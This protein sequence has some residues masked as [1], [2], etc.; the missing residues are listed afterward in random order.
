MTYP[1]LM[2]A[3]HNIGSMLVLTF[4]GAH[5]GAVLLRDRT[6]ALPREEPQ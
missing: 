2:S 6:R 3:V 5:L 1:P 4:A